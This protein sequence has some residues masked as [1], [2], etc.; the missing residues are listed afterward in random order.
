MAGSSDIEQRD[1][2]M[3]LKNAEVDTNGVRGMKTRA[4]GYGPCTVHSGNLNATTAGDLCYN[5]R[6]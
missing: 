1:P 3:A 6:H 4:S 5:Y 2:N